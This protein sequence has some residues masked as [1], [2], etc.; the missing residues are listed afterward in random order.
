M[1]I[2]QVA[3]L[4]ESVPPRLHGGTERIGRATYPETGGKLSNENSLDCHPGDRAQR[5]APG[6]RLGAGRF[7]AGYEEPSSSA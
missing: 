5:T 7:I 2:A 1:K 4:I 3:P 6:G